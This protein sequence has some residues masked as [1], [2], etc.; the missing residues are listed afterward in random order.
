MFVSFIFAL[1]R[2]RTSCFRLANN[3]IRESQHNDGRNEVE[4]IQDAAST[5]ALN[6]FSDQKIASSLPIQRGLQQHMPRRNDVAFRESDGTTTSLSYSQAQNRVRTEKKKNP[7]LSAL[8]R[9]FT[10]VTSSSREAV[11]SYVPPASSFNSNHT[12]GYERP[13][14]SSNRACRNKL[15]PIPMDFRGSVE[16]SESVFNEDTERAMKMSLSLCKA[17]PSIP[18]LSPTSPIKPLIKRVR[19]KASKIMRD[20]KTTP[21]S[22]I[23][24][25]TIHS[26]IAMNN[27][28]MP[29]L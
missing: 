21:N 4:V 12:S 9:P 3:V 13:P 25:A 29:I 18:N 19:T 27:Q 14:N 24:A 6:V 22:K 20:K 2:P 8:K 7:S 17:P 16:E 28:G 26:R 10:G 23:V 5:T 1:T 15:S 11:K